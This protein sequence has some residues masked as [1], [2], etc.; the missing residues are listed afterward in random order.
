MAGPLG[1]GR[2]GRVEACLTSRAGGPWPERSLLGGGPGSSGDAWLPFRGR[3]GSGKGAVFH[4]AEACLPR[5]ERTANGA[6][7]AARSARYGCRRHL[8]LGCGARCLA[9]RLP[10]WQGPCQQLEPWEG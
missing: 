10:A 3:C 1:P 8:D 4:F 2:Q 7:R 9:A 6:W 5:A